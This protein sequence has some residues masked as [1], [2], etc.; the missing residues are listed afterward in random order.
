MAAFATTCCLVMPRPM[1]AAS[2]ILFPSLILTS[3]GNRVCLLALVSMGTLPESLS[4]K[5]VLGTRK[6]LL[7]SHMDR[8]CVFTASAGR[9]KARHHTGIETFSCMSHDLKH[10]CHDH[11]NLK[12]E[13]YDLMKILLYAQRTSREKG[14]QR[15]FMDTALLHVP[16]I[17]A[18]F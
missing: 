12:I 7:A 4:C 17:I 18:N 8:N 3:G 15:K 9:V 2:L 16:D 13:P 5:V 1:F 6:C 11:Y 14:P 10:R